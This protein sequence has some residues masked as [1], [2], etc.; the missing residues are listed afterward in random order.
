MNAFALAGAA[1]FLLACDEGPVAH[2][3]GSVAATIG[4]DPVP[5]AADLQ[6]S[7]HAHA[8]V[9]V[10]NGRGWIE[11]GGGSM[12]DVALRSEAGWS[13]IQDQ[14]VL[15]SGTYSRVRLT[16]TGATARLRAGRDH[17]DGTG[18]EGA[19]VRVGSGG[20][21][22]IEREVEPFMIAGGIRARLLFELNSQEWLDAAAAADG[23][24]D[25]A[26][27]RDAATVRRVVEPR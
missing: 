6:G 23:Y 16:L 2:G 5:A 4:D 10:S 7:F 17:G 20:P 22:V 3:W 21:I 14:A 15:P 11:L 9:A 25:P 27:L 13:D 19:M 12:I 8:S 24:A 18:D 26:R 1:A